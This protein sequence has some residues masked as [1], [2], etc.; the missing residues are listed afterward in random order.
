ME[1]SREHALDAIRANGVVRPRDL[2]PLGI[3]RVQLSRLVEKGLV[4]RVARGL[5][6]AADA[7]YTE[8]HTFAEAAKRAPRGV[9]CLLSALHFHGLTTQLPR[10]VWMAIDGKARLPKDS[11]PPLRFVRF[12]PLALSEGVEEHDI[13]GVLVKVFDPAKTVVDCFKYR[14]KIGQD[15]ALEALRDCARA[16]KCNVDD[17]WWYAQ[18]ERMTKVMAPYLEAVF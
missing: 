12:S 17:L 4:E 11:S 1:T 14:S 16:R 18:V 6:V 5:Y 9:I 8:Q 15:I 7:Q 3:S 10:E 13:E 2:A